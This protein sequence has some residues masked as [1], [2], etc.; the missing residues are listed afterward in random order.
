MSKER[1]KET[2]RNFQKLDCRLYHFF[3]CVEAKGLPSKT[4]NETSFSQ[5]DLQ[6]KYHKEALL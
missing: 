2:F 6:R 1:A 5:Y 3:T 4:F